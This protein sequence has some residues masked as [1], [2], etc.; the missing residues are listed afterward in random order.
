MGPCKSFIK[1]THACAHIDTPAQTHVHA[2][3]PQTPPLIRTLH[4][5]YKWTLSA[6]FPCSSSPSLPPP[7]AIALHEAVSIYYVL[8]IL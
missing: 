2:D 5:H 8:S 3:V 6:L 4:Q 1:D 7:P